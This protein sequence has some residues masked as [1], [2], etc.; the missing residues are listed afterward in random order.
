MAEAYETAADQAKTYPYAGYLML[1]A[2]AWTDVFAF[3]EQDADAQGEPDP[4]R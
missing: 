2:E 1:P 3:F 4:H